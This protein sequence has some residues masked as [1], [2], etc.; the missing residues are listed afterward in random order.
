M[1]IRDSVRPPVDVKKK[2]KNIVIKEGRIMSV[3]SANG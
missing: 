3:G 2:K 1:C